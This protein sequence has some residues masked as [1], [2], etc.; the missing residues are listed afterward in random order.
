MQKEKNIYIYKNSKTSWNIFQDR[1][2]SLL[3]GAIDSR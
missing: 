2:G 1:H 3:I